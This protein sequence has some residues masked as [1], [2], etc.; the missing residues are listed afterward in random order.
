MVDGGRGHLSAA[1]E[2][3]TELGVNER[4]DW[5]GIAKE[6][7][8]EGEKLYKPGWKNPITLAKHDPALLYLMRIRDEAHRF[9]ITFHRRLRGKNSLT[10]QLATIPGIGVDRQRTLLKHFGSVR[11]LRAATLSE[12]QEAPGIGGKL[13]ALIFAHL[14]D[15][16]KAS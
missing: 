4:L 5:L 6:R 13:A 12:L 3:A 10:S 8:E 9:G 11:G 1:M 14:H 2:V 7:A 16:K 15:Q